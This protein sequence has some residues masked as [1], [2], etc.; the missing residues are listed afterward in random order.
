MAK[1]IRINKVNLGRNIQKQKRSKAKH[2]KKNVAAHKEFLKKAHMQTEQEGTSTTAPH[3]TR[4]RSTRQKKIAKKM[5]QRRERSKSQM[6]VTSESTAKTTAKPKTTKA[7]KTTGEKESTKK[8]EEE[9]EDD[10]DEMMCD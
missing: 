7:T 4:F 6:D 8:T 2:K 10:N 1:G 3:L 9:V 5:T